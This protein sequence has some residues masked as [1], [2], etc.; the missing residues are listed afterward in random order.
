MTHLV[1]PPEDLIAVDEIDAIV[2]PDTED[3]RRLIRAIAQ[4]RVQPQEGAA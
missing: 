3:G 1:A 2:V 4:A